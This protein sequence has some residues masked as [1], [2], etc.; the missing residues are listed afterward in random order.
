[1]STEHKDQSAAGIEVSHLTPKERDEVAELAAKKVFDKAYAEFG[2]N[3][4]RWAIF[5]LGLGLIYVFTL[6]AKDWHPFK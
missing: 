6:I 3:A 1:M 2:K 5:A 4:L